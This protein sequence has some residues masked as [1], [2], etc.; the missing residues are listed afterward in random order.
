VANANHDP[1]RA[2]RLLGA[3]RAVHESI[4]AASN[5][6]SQQLFTTI[7]EQT[8]SLLDEEIF[9]SAWEEGKAMTMEQAIEYALEENK[10]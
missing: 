1:V 6:Q 7:T 4:G 5:P 9:Q 3:R 2:G 8:K 10:S